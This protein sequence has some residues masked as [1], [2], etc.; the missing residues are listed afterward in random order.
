MNLEK[1]KQTESDLIALEKSIL[2]DA[3]NGKL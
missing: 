2:H 3:F 1:T